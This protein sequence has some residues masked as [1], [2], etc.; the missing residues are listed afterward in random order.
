[1]NEI[2]FKAWL[3]SQNTIKKVQGDLISRIKRL[4]RVFGNIDLD[5]EYQ[6]DKCCFLLSLFK[7]KGVNSEM[8]KF[9]IA[10]LPIGQYQLS[11]YKYALKKYISFIESECL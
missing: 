4:E 11:T 9:E 6:K 7:N 1:M 2:D 10:E 5:E 3:R 8:N